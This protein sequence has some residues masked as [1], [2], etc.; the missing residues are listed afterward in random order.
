[1]VWNAARK[2]FVAALVL[3]LLWV[4]VLAALVVVSAYRPAARSAQPLAQ[5]AAAKTPDAGAGRDGGRSGMRA[6]VTTG[7]EGSGKGD[8]QPDDG[9]GAQHATELGST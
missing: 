6:D 4:A 1:M 3:F 5:L 7:P 2:R 8:L 9:G